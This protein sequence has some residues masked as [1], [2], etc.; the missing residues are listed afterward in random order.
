MQIILQ[1]NYI[2]YFDCVYLFIYLFILNKTK[3]KNKGIYS[4]NTPEACHYITEHSKSE[5]LCVDGNKQLVKYTKKAFPHL[6]AIVMWD[7]TIDPK[8]ASNCSVPVY[9][10]E[11]FLK[12]GDQVNDSDLVTRQAK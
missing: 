8:I 1:L 2:K 10:W 12:L 7:E 6:K 9:S 5:V 4:T 3:Q 11:A